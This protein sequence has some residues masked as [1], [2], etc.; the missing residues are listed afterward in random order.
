MHLCNRQKK[1][2]TLL[3]LFTN[4]VDRHLCRPVR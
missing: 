1:V 4:L 2:L 3:E